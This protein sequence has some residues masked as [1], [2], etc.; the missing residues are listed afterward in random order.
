MRGFEMK[1]YTRNVF[2]SEIEYQCKHANIAFREMKQAI[3]E[4]RKKTNAMQPPG[5]WMSEL[6]DKV[7]FAAHTFLIAADNV[8]KLLWP[9]RKK[10]EARG[11]ELRGLLGVDD[12][13]VLSSRNFRNSYEHFD[14]RLD[15]WADSLKHKNFIDRNIGVVESSTGFNPE[16]CMRNLDPKSLTLSFRGENYHTPIISEALDSIHLTAKRISQYKQL[17]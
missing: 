14:E 10:S 8:S 11:K 1:E 4:L 17:H 9:S 12:N 7:F 5:L 2:I 16:D 15:D 6:I 3:D 13:N